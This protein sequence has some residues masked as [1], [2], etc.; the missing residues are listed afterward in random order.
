MKYWPPNL[1]SEEAVEYES[2][3]APPGVD[4][5]VLLPPI[6]WP[7][8]VNVSVCEKSKLVISMAYNNAKIYL[9]FSL[10]YF[11]T[12]LMLHKGQVSSISGKSPL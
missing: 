8:D 2:A 11:L 3:E 9:S 12:S 1:L 5:L 7:P 4:W 10:L 6:F